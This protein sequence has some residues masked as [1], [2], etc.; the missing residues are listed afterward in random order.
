MPRFTLKNDLEMQLIL[1]KYLGV[2]ALEDG[3]I[4]AARKAIEE[5]EKRKEA[6]S[7]AAR[8]AVEEIGVKEILS[9][10]DQGLPLVE[11]NQKGAHPAILM[12]VAGSFAEIRFPHSVQTFLPGENNPDEWRMVK[13]DK[14]MIHISFRTVQVR[15][16]DG[17]EKGRQRGRMFCPLVNLD[18]LRVAVAAWEKKQQE[19]RDALG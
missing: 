8:R 3:K 11:M 6:A 18:S 7:R 4:S 13:L 15:L 9:D 17:G 12:K 10:E 14:A 19:R 16:A 5:A 1:E 2:A